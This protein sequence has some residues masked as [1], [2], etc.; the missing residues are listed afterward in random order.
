MFKRFQWIGMAAMLCAVVACSEDG[1]DGS[2]T[3][4]DAQEDFNSG[5]VPGTIPD[6]SQD[7]QDP[8]VGQDPEYLVGDPCLNSGDCPGGYC[9]KR[10]DGCVECYTNAHCPDEEVCFNGECVPLEECTSS[11]DCGS[12]VCIAEKCV[13]CES[14][15]DCKGTFECIA[16]VCRPKAQTCSQ[17]ADCQPFGAVCDTGLGHCVDCEDNS[18]CSPEEY[19]DIPS[20]VPKP[21]VPGAV[22]CDGNDVVVC[23]SNGSGQYSFPCDEGLTCFNGECLSLTC[24][25]GEVECVKHQVK[26]CTPAGNLVLK[27]CPPGQECSNG[28]CVQMR[29][30]VLVVFDTSGSMNLIAGSEDYPNLCEAG[31]EG[32]CLEPWPT[33]ES[34]TTPFTTL[35]ISKKVFSQFFKSDDTQNVFFGLQRFPQA[36]KN[37]APV[38]DGGYFKG[39]TII[40]GDTGTHELPLPNS[41]WF[42]QNLSEIILVPFPPPNSSSNLLSLIQWIDFSE[43]TFKTDKGCATS[44]DCVNGVCLGSVGNKKCHT[45]TNPELRAHGWTPL[46]KSLYYAGEYF[47][48]YVVVDGRACQTDADCGSQGYYCNEVGKCYDPLKSCRLNVI[49][50]F[51]DG[52]ETQFPFT[53]D[54]FNPQVQA[55]RLRYGLGCQT[56]SDCSSLDY[57]QPKTNDKNCTQNSD[58]VATFP[59]CNIEGK[60][61]K[62]VKVQSDLSCV[63]QH[64]KVTD[65]AGYCTNDILEAKGAPVIQYKDTALGA[66]RLV[67]GNG[68]PINLVVNVVDA[69]TV[70]PEQSTAT[71]NNNYQIALNGGGLHV[72]VS[73][74]DEA[75]F[76][77]KLKATIDSKSLYSQ[78]LVQP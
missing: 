52:G 62:D 67:D 13:E 9:D 36:A 69:S 41:T 54:F 39:D 44:S 28:G 47:R 50:L 78:C 5:D 38:C 10:K 14:D 43:K 30:R 77:K 45:F 70:D 48:K 27:S 64:C 58:C 73:V 22:S 18:Q 68:N 21:C 37:P 4:Q 20:C 57:C 65:G 33:C 76:L 42:D 71:L 66:D 40:T 1:D 25:P 24:T 2:Q 59:I 15:S 46:G 26:E 11:A 6:S 29:Q 74:N 32:T 51:T 3:T 31:S 61:E 72:V 75:D 12:G 53:N 19:C 60:C 49:V 56:D 34:S 8:D 35:G 7:A 16:N 23:K 55:K 63:K 17:N